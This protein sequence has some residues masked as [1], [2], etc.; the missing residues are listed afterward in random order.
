MT[1]Q[2][3]QLLDPSLVLLDGGLLGENLRPF[4]DE[5]FLSMGKCDRMNTIGAGN[6]ADRFGPGQNFHEHLK[7][8]PRR[9]PFA[10]LL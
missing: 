10:V 7:L 4:L 5:L 2:P 1:D 3:F 6:L 8:E 9:V